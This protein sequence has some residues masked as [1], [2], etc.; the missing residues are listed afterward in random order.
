MFAQNSSPIDKERYDFL[1]DSLSTEKNN[2]LIEK[3][4]LISKLVTFLGAAP[5]QSRVEDYVE[6][7]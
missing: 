7:L 4:K 3:A 6:M 2:L 5:E 1:Y